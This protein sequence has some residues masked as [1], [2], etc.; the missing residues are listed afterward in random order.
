MSTLKCI[1]I[2][3]LGLILP[4]IMAN[5]QSV[6]SIEGTITD[7]SGAVVANANITAKSLATDVETTRTTNESGLF[8]LQV[9][10]A[11]VE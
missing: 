11:L 10:P 4:A 9:A 8:V 3:S 5:A 1:G 6:G 7:P 2:F